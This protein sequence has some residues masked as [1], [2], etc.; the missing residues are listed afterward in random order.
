VRRI[1]R[2]LRFFGRPKDLRI[3]KV[4][5]PIAGS[6]AMNDGPVEKPVSGDDDRTGDPD[7][8]LQGGNHC[9][10]LPVPDRR[11][12]TQ[13]APGASLAPF[14]KFSRQKAGLE[15]N[16][17]RIRGDGPL[18]KQQYFNIDLQKNA[19]ATQAHVHG[20]FDSPGPSLN[21]KRR[22]PRSAAPEFI[23]SKKY[24]HI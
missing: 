18:L 7:F 23:T 13:L 21:E 16:K 17:F 19:Y 12:R 20:K 3:A 1:E 6:G 2:F 15:E 10:L 22:F 14:R 9:Y 4:L 8:L 5:T 24:L 11:A